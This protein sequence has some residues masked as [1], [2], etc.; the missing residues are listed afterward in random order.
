MKNNADLIKKRRKKRATDDYECTFIS[1]LQ[2]AGFIE[3]QKMTL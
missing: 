2:V 1:Q 3:M